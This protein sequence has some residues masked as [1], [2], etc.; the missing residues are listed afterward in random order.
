M[1]SDDECVYIY[2]T[3]LPAEEGDGLRMWYM[4]DPDRVLYAESED[5]VT[6]HRPE[7]GLVE[8]DGRT[9]NNALPIRLHSP[10]VIHDPTDS[11]SG[12]RYKMLG[13]SHSPESRGYCTAHSAD[14]L[15]WQLYDTN[16]VLT[17]GDTCCLAR[18]LA[19]GDYFA[20]HKRYDT[21]RGH[22][23]RLV[24]LS[25]SPDMQNWSEPALVMAPDEDDDAQTEAEGGRRSPAL[26]HGHYDDPRR[27][28]AEEEDHHRPGI[29]AAGRLG[30]ARRRGDAG[31]RGD[32]AH[33]L[34]GSA[35]DRQRRGPGALGLPPAY[36]GW[37][38]SARPLEDAQRPALLPSDPH[39]LPAQQRQPLQLLD[40]IEAPS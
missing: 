18:D 26:L 11:D 4:R 35:P 13:V 1:P 38:P 28:P 27:L 34:G 37:R 16:P 39:P 40:R 24:Y 5:G 6:W 8:N 7:L 25:S 2:G 19:T 33:A 30:V 14:G 29:L 3:V 31:R 21:C 36:R 22:R 15:N 20:F 12:R 23:R 9:R 10:S 17:G 32:H